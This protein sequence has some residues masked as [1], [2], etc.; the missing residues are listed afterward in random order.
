MDEIFSPVNRE[1]LSMVVARKLR[2]AIVGG[3]LEDGTALPSEKDLAQRMGVG[4]SS[5]RE[6]LRILQAQGLVSGGDRVTTKGAMVSG[7]GVLPSAVSALS[8]VMLLGR[9]PLGD[10]LAL[11]LLV[12]AAALRRAAVEGDEAALGRASAALDEMRAADGDV[13][14]FHRADVA[15]HEALVEASNNR[16]FGLVM[17]VLHETMEHHLRD[18]LEGEDD[19][20]PVVARLTREH[21][22]ILDAIRRRNGSEAAELVIVHLRGFYEP[23]LG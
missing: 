12:E 16:A 22:A 10:L 11:R 2:D 1:P 14:R 8:N 18:A 6:A 7:R 5:V 9:V 13:G 19:P 4:R 3:E 20:G 23:R 17:S 15:F 21:E